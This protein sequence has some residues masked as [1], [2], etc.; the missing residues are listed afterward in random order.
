MEGINVAFRVVY[1]VSFIGGFLCAICPLAAQQAPPGA[2]SVVD[3]VRALP[4]GSHSLNN[5]VARLVAAGDEGLDELLR[6]PDTRIQPVELYAIGFLTDQDNARAVERLEAFG[7]SPVSRELRTAALDGLIRVGGAGIGRILE[8]LQKRQFDAPTLEYIFEDLWMSP[9][10]PDLDKA[11]AGIGELAEN[12]GDPEFATMIRRD[13]PQRIEKALSVKKNPESEQTRKQL[14]DILHR[15]DPN[16]ASIPG[17]RPQAWAVDR[18]IEYQVPGAAEEIRLFL[19]NTKPSG[20]GEG[21]GGVGPDPETRAR[22]Y[23]VY[24]LEDLVGNLPQE[25]RT[26]LIGGKAPADLPPGMRSEL[27]VLPLHPGVTRDR[28]LDLYERSA[29]QGIGKGSGEEES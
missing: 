5:R 9:D 18:L 25:E 23:L 14:L 26:K 21:K 6:V 2:S 16:F 3:E 12:A 15:R 8:H 19:E 11:L 27:D 20:F 1:T 7:F 10:T 28:L 22:L 24:R 13:A 4:E 29:A 17:W